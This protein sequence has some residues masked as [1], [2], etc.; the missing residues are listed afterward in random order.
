MAARRRDQVDGRLDALEQEV[1]ELRQGQANLRGQVK[2]LEKGTR[3]VSVGFEG[4]CESL[5]LAREPQKEY[6][7]MRRETAQEKVDQAVAVGEI[8]QMM[9]VDGVLLGVH[10]QEGFDAASGHRV[11]L[12][13]KF[14]LVLETCHET[15]VIR[16]KPRTLDRHLRR[17]SGL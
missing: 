7:D 8:Q 12:P 10:A 6:R 13:G 1:A 15:W 2:R 4:P 5:W 3:L 14:N 11:R 16:S 17:A 9:S